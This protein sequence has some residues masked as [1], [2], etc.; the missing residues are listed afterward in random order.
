VLPGIHA[1]LRYQGFGAG[2]GWGKG[3]LDRSL[4]V[5]PSR[6]ESQVLPE[7]WCVVGGL[8]GFEVLLL[9]QRCRSKSRDHDHSPIGL[10]C[11]SLSLVHVSI[12]HN[13]CLKVA[14]SGGTR[15]QSDRITPL[16]LLASTS[17]NLCRGGPLSKPSQCLASSSKN[18]R[19]QFF[20]M[21]NITDRPLETL[22]F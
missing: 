11:V 5:L 21:S 4:V 20:L 3:L 8:G 22:T 7:S 9:L 18:I 16:T 19:E 12:A 6:P 17:R 13:S 15:P 14:L 2:I 10:G 1:L